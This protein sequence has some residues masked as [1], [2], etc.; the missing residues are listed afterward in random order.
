M[1]YIKS[2]I[3]LALWLISSSSY[4]QTTA[5]NLGTTYSI[6]PPINEYL[7]DE[8]SL[9]N[10][11]KMEVWQGGY[12][13]QFDA[14]SNSFRL[15]EVSKCGNQCFYSSAGSFTVLPD[16]QI[17]L[18]L[19]QQSV[20]GSSPCSEHYSKQMSVNLGIFQIEPQA[21]GSILLKRVKQLD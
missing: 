7:V 19:T 1:R 3:L 13:I 12:R 10:A 11:E 5:L 2:F 16:N 18:T 9:A 6:M 14:K 15:Y 17:N 4:A 20:D 8:Y 21:N